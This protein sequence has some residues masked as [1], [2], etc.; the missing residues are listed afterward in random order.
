MQLLLVYRS[1]STRSVFIGARSMQARSTFSSK[2]A[3]CVIYD[4]AQCVLQAHIIIKSHLWREVF[5]WTNVF[6]KDQK[7]TLGDNSHRCANLVRTVYTA[8]AEYDMEAGEDGEA[9]RGNHD[10]PI[11]N[12]RSQ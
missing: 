11:G 7:L 10:W 4:G 2:T 9:E 12:Y 8:I 1:G 3:L 5:K 6:L